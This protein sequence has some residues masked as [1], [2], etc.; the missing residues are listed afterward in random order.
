[1]KEIMQQIDGDAVIRV[2]PLTPDTITIQQDGK[3]IALS[4]K[5]VAE[6]AMFACENNFIRQTVYELFKP[7]TPIWTQNEN[8]KSE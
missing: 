7:G 8:E 5:A 3:S 4:Q 6:L 2:S 1:M